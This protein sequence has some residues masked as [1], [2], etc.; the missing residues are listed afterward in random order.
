MSGLTLVQSYGLLALLTLAVRFPAFG[1]CPCYLKIR[2]Q[3][4]VQTL[5]YFA[6]K[7]VRGLVFGMVKWE[8]PSLCALMRFEGLLRFLCFER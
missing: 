5:L 2:S 3:V 1:C 7:C 6:L 8:A 4:T